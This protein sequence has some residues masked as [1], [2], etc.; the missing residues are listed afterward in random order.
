MRICIVNSKMQ[1]VALDRDT[2]GEGI[3]GLAPEV[4]DESEYIMRNRWSDRRIDKNEFYMLYGYEGQKIKICHR[5]LRLINMKRWIPEF[6]AAVPLRLCEKEIIESVL[7]F[8]P[9]VILMTGVRF[10]RR[11]QKILRKHYPRWTC[12]TDLGERLDPGERGRKHNLFSRVSIV[13]PTYNGVKYIRQSIESCLNQ[14]FRNIELIV[15]D[16]GSEENIGEIAN[17]YDDPRLKYIRHESNL[18]IAEALNTGFRNSTGEYLTW[19]SDD[20]YYTENAIEEMARFLQTYP[21]IDFVY[22][23]NYIIDE[24]HPDQAKIR[25]SNPPDWLTINNDIGACFL[26]KRKVYKTIGDFKQKAFLTEDYDYWLRVWRRFKMQRLFRPLY[27]YRFHEGSLTSRYSPKE[28]SEQLQWAKQ[29]NG[30][31][32]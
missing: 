16:D 22:A 1:I 24:R 6:I 23:D 19:T 15:V 2:L 25:R 9:D 26:Y 20:N 27:Y 10:G 32:E 28:V 8:D 11:F 18:G 3:N 7:G 21:D 14:T 17:S 13:L 12:I 4:K 29:Q 30:I 5:A 31:R